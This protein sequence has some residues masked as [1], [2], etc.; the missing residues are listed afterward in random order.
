MHNCIANDFAIIL[1]PTLAQAGYIYP[2]TKLDIETHLHLRSDPTAHP[3][4]ISFN[5]DPTSYHCC[6]Y[7]TIG[8]DITITGT[9]PPPKCHTSEDIIQ[10]ITANADH[11][12]Q[13][14]KRHKLGRI[15]KLATTT[16]PPVR[17]EDVIGKLFH[18]NM[19]LVPITID[20][21]ARFGPMSQSFLTSTDAP[22]QKPWFTTHRLEKFNRPKANLMYER[23][24]NPPNT[25]GILTLADFFCKQLQSPTRR[26]FYRHSYT[27]PTPSIHTLQQ[28][29][30]AFLKGFSSLL[31][32]ATRTF[33][34]PPTAQRFDLSLY[35]PG[36]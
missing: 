9:T 11:Y 16:T 2:N 5:V 34:E 24:S 28:L 12:L 15:N 17:G 18:K 31:T 35:E 25:L 7:T 1:S 30:V 8:A 10:T 32:N 13:M 21:F 19:V 26:T 33:L 14:H 3:F 29:G 27:A 6:P 22:P 20:P 36:P 4:D 23:A